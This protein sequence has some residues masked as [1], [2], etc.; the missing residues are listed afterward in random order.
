MSIPEGLRPPRLVRQPG[1]IREHPISPCMGHSY[2]DRSRIKKVML[3]S[4]Q[5]Q[6]IEIE[7]CKVEL[8]GL[9]ERHAADITNQ[10]EQLDRL[11]CL[12]AGHDDYILAQTCLSTVYL[13]TR[14]LNE[15]DGIYTTWENQEGENETENG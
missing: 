7:R 13:R 3:D 12:P 15:S 4:L 2:V 11:Y 9:I 1:Q 5:R 14:V 10:N 8:R 6:L